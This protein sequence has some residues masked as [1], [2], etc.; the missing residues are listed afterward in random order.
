MASASLTAPSLTA[1][2]QRKQLIQLHL[3]DPQVMQE[4]LREGAQLLRRLH[5]PLQHRIGVHLE[6]PRRAPDA[7]PLGQARD[8]AHDQLRGHTLAVEDRPEGLQKVAATDD[9]QQLPPGTPTGIAISTE[10]APVHPAAIGTVGVG[11]EMR[12]GVHLATAPPCGH[13]A[14]WGS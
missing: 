1:L 5:E 10:I 3:P 7:Q 11:A 13:D 2:R 9:A 6:H 8:D 14:G 12:G 4:V